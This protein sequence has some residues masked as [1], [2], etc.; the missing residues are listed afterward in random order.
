MKKKHDLSPNRIIH[1]NGRK[2]YKHTTS[3]KI[4]SPNYETN[5]ERIDQRIKDIHKIDPN[6]NGQNYT[7]F[8]AQ[9]ED[10]KSKIVQIIYLYLL[11][12]QK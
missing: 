11:M 10:E 4:K 7:T 9:R 12:D 8:I 5:L 2:R 3:Q 1:P 6:N